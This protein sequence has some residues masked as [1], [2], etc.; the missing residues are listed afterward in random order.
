M[1]KRLVTFFF[2]TIF[3]VTFF[4]AILLTLAASL[5]AAR[6]LPIVNIA[7]V[8]DGPSERIASIRTLFIEEMRAV[9][10]GEFDIQAPIELQQ[11][12]D[13]TLAGVR[14][15][16]NQVLTDSRTDVVVTLGVLGS[17]AA[18]QSNS[19]PKPVVAPVIPNHSLQNIPYQDGVSGKTNLSYVSLDVDIRRDLVAFDKIVPFTR[20]T[21]LLDGAIAQAIPGINDEVARVAKE[22]NIAITPVLGGETAASILRDIPEDTQ[23]VYVGP[24]PALTTV[25]YQGLVNGLIERRLPS[26][27]FNGKADVARGL[28]IGISP[29]LEMDRLARRVALNVRRI[30]LGEK[31]SN[32]PVAFARSEGLTINMRT[33][34]AIGFSPHWKLLTNAELL[35]D[36]PQS[37]GPPLTLAKAVRQ[38][39]DKNLSLRVAQSNV[40]AAKENIREARSA[41]LPQ[42]GLSGRGVFIDEDDARAVP[43]RAERTTSGSLTLDQLIYSET[44]WANLNIQKQLQVARE[45]EREQIRLDIMLETAQAY[46]D[47]L[48]AQINTRVQKD[49]LRLSRSN[50]E[51]A[52]SRRRI[53]TAGPSEVYRWESR[54]ANSKRAVVEAQSQTRVAEIALN[55]LLHRPLEDMINAVEVGLSEPILI[56]S[57]QQLFKMIDNPASYRIL[58]D[59]IV[60]DAFTSVPELRQLD[61]LIKAQERSLKSAS[62]ANWHPRVHLRA[63]RTETFERSG[64]QGPSLPGVDD[65]ET[66]VAVE[67]SLPL[68]TSGARDAEKVK[69]HEALSG[70]RL[71]RQAT[72]EHIEQRVRTALHT[73]Q[74]TYTAIRLS[75]QAADAAESHFVVVRD[76]YSRGTLSILDLLDAQ[77]AALVADLRAATAVFDFVSALMEVERAAARFDFFLSP[78]D[79]ASWL[80]RVK[81]YFSEQGVP[82]L[83]N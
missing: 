65:T 21:I 17:H 3:S 41:L 68:F 14:L 55:A 66:T 44:T 24:L 15:A 57:Q 38:A 72:A 11:E 16:L 64:V 39:L 34:R 54:I 82:G 20:L 60:Q 77:N 67:L 52:R 13:R 29:A 27:A 51:L 81:R 48:R 22:L 76:A 70:L 7:I 61:A 33:A 9:N 49:N 8:A 56:T 63:D 53:G 71:L 75:H 1:T 18:A 36:E 83:P 59:F 37:S 2:A 46:L 28:L 45:N 26:F 4:S 6:Q 32:L 79:Q 25:E 42:L 30:L 58:R 73:S 23:A 74:S 47:V 5:A 62:N 43:G 40:I 35:N 78:D 50:L 80:E 12:G 69:A 10:R 31:A 19:L